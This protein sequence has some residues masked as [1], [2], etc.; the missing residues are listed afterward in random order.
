MVD[1]IS[2]TINNG[3]MATSLGVPHTVATSAEGFQKQFETAM[4]T[5]GPS[6][7]DAKVESFRNVLVAFQMKDRN[8]P[9]AK[10]G[11]GN[12]GWD[13]LPPE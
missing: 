2:P 9:N 12:K 4:N 1:L 6:F 13:V 10:D 7:I 8:M 11:R 3:E 5:K